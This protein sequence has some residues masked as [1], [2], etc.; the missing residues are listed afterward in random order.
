M[1]SLFILFTSGVIVGMQRVIYKI[2][3]P[4]LNM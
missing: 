3:G 2:D 1:L 4:Q